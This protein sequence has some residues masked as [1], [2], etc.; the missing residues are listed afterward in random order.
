MT[1]ELTRLA[2]KIKRL[3]EEAKSHED[4]KKIA[5]FQVNHLKEKIEKIKEQFTK[6]DNGQ[7]LWNPTLVYDIIKKEL[8]EDNA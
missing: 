5:L 8:L 2:E 3:E 6:Q 1:N 4:F 7:Y